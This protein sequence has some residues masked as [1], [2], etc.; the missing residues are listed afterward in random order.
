MLLF[1]ASK[2]CTFFSFKKGS[3]I[4]PFVKSPAVHPYIF[5]QLSSHLQSLMFLL[6]GK[7]VLN[8]IKSQQNC[9][10][11]D[12]SQVSVFTSL[13]WSALA[14]K[15]MQDNS[16]LPPSS[17]RR[18]EVYYQQQQR[19]DILHWTVYLRSEKASGWLGRATR[20]GTAQ[21][22]PWLHRAVRSWRPALLHQDL[23]AQWAEM[24]SRA[25]GKWGRWAGLVWPGRTLRAQT[26]WTRHL[27]QLRTSGKKWFQV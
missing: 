1:I 18:D 10:N 20:T 23:T 25:M 2:K 5:I 22:G 7:D 16:V 6:F 11:S 19:I 8:I 26:L 3:T 15:C 21:W 14:K 24:A 4:I 13:W 17:V 9:T 27:K 12:F